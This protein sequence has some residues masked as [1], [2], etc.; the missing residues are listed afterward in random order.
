[1]CYTFA[2]FIDVKFISLIAVT[3]TR[4]NDA[5]DRGVIF[6]HQSRKGKERRDLHVDS[7]M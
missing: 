2:I 4:E 7:A 5:L 1:M 6:I 3:T